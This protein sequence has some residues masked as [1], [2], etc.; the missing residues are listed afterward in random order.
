MSQPLFDEAAVREG[1]PEARLTR[2]DA[3]LEKGWVALIEA[4]PFGT[5]AHVTGES[6]V[7][8]VEMTAR[9]GADARCTCPDFRDSGLKCKHVVATAMV[10]ARADEFELETVNARLPRLRDQLD[11][12]GYDDPDAEV[13]RAR[14][15]P[16]LLKALEGEAVD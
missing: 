5:V 4:G 10:A 8:V 9:D 11:M 16:A 1:V 3:Y 7:Y 12:E 14:R 2:A 13:D 15:D 6:G